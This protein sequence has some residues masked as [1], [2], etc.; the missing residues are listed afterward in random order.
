[1]NALLKKLNN[2]LLFQDTIAL[3]RGVYRVGES[4]NPLGSENP[5]RKVS[6]MD[7]PVS[8]LNSPGT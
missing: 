5:T 6:W 7:T 8:E 3:M 2:S 1:M 4:L